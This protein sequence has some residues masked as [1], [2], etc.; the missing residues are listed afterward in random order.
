MSQTFHRPWRVSA[1]VA[2]L[3][4]S[5]GPPGVQTGAGNLGSAQGIVSQEAQMFSF[6]QWNMCGLTDSTLDREEIL[7]HTENVGIIRYIVRYI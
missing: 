2:K 5:P 7:N 6:M 3:I 4:P 1:K